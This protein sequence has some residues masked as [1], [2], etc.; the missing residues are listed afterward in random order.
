MAKR[1]EEFRTLESLESQAGRDAIIKLLGRYQTNI[2]QTM[3]DLNAMKNAIDLTAAKMIAHRMCGAC[4]SLGFMNL[5]KIFEEMD[6][7][8]DQKN[9]TDIVRLIESA[10]QESVA[11]AAAIYSRYPETEKAM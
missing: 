7:A 2:R 11:V 4:G 5:S 1:D 3:M 10:E 6:S 9:T 8:I